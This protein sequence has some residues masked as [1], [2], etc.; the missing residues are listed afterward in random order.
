MLV[1]PP[2]TTTDGNILTVVMG[3][4]ALRHDLVCVFFALLAT[5][6]LLWF[7]RTGHRRR[8]LG[9]AAAL[10][11]AL[12]SKEMAAALFPF[13]AALAVAAARWRPFRAAHADPQPFG[14][15]ILVSAGVG[16][17]TGAVWGAFY[18]VACHRMTAPA[19]ASHTLAGWAAMLRQRWP[20]PLYM[21][22]FSLSRP[23][24]HLFYL[25]RTR[26]T[27][28]EALIYPRFWEALL[29]SAV[30]LAGLALL[31]RRHKWCAFALYAW[32]VT[33]YLPVLPMSD[34][35]PWFEYMPHI[36]DRIYTVG[37]LWALWEWPPVGARVGPAVQRWA[38]L[39]PR[40]A[41]ESTPR[42]S[43]P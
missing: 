35:F 39:L 2:S 23:V 21:F 18:W 20:T 11:A 3:G 42:G 12:F 8:L 43:E 26:I 16:L 37:V 38:A 13:F 29:G 1:P 31:W 27:W 28:A 19:P 24:G 7:W 14:R 41:C 5:Q 36:L 40:P 15:R 6:Q 34:T 4:A 25:T 32:K 9:F 17:L 33:A 22:V 30:F 10:S